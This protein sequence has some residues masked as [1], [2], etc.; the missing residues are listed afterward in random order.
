MIEAPLRVRPSRSRM[1][2]L[3][4]PR[5]N[6]LLFGA[7]LFAPPV[8]SINL[9]TSTK[10]ES[11]LLASFQL[12]SNLFKPFFPF[13]SRDHDVQARP[14]PVKSCGWCNLCYRQSRFGKL[15]LG[16]SSS[17]SAFAP[18]ATLVFRRRVQAFKTIPWC[19]EQALSFFELRYTDVASTGS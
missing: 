1:K 17:K 5:T 14:A 3:G 2:L 6:S 18:R 13:L 7:T 10:L 12:H 11:S 19:Y 9:V 4:S 8:S 16:T 15:S